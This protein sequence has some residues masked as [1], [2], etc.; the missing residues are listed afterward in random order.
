M[1]TL[2]INKGRVSQH[3]GV[4]LETG[5]LSSVRVMGR[6]RVELAKGQSVDQRWLALNGQDII[7]HEETKLSFKGSE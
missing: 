3:V 1:A 5:E 6:S 7:V 2:V 4:I